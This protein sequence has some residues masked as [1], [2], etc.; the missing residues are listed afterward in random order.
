MQWWVEK[1]NYFLIF[2]IASLVMA[3][4]YL[5]AQQKKKALGRFANRKPIS[6]VQQLSPYFDD[7]SKMEKAVGLW[8]SFAQAYDIS[9]TLLRPEDKLEEIISSDIF[10]D[11]GLEFELILQEISGEKE[12]EKLSLLEFVSVIAIGA[13]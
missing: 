9:P 5:S 6:P 1:M 13:E 11:K 12:F 3:V 10:G 2:V 4:A 7:S 8:N